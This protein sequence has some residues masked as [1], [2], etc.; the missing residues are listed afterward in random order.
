MGAEYLSNKKIDTKAIKK[1]VHDDIQSE[2]DS[3]DNESSDYNDEMHE[4]LELDDNNFNEIEQFSDDEDDEKIDHPTREIDS[5]GY[6]HASHEYLEVDDDE[7]N[8]IE[9]F[10]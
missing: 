4:Y 9:Q 5:S 2:E 1:D 8:E 7:N 3:V 6:N 10:S